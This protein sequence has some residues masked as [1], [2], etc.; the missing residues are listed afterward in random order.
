MDMI[1]RW[2]LG[3][4]NNVFYYIL[5]FVEYKTDDDDNDDYNEDFIE[6]LMINK[7]KTIQNKPRQIVYPLFHIIQQVHI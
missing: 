2:L 7:W 4:N 1:Q 6:N 5:H 3:K